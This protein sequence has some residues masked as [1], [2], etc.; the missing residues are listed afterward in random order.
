MK[1]YAIEK[2]PLDFCVSK[3]Q[4][5]RIV[6]TIEGKPAALMIGIDTEQSEQGS[7]ASF[8]R[9]I[10]DRRREETVSRNALEQMIDSG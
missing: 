3:A 2:T 6:L 1:T 10:E 8:W 5:E 7:D 4:F 9:L